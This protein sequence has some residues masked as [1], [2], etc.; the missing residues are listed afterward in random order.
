MGLE[1]ATYIDDLVITNP[2]GADDR[3]TADDHI[4]LVKAVLKTTFPTINGAVTASLAEINKLD[5]L[6]ASQTELNQLTSRTLASNDDV[7]DNF[8]AGILALFQQS[9]AP[10]GWT[11]QATHNNKALRVVSGTASSGGSVA[12]TTVFGRT[13]TDAYTLLEADVPAH[14]HGTTGDH[15]HASAGAHTHTVRTIGTLS[16]SSDGLHWEGSGDI[17][18]TAKAGYVNSNGSHTHANAGAHTHTSFG[19]GGSHTHGADMRV[20]YVDVIIASKD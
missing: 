6:T 17:L 16:G 8:E 12:F 14:D 7:I 18:D 15:G 2:A 20:T 11:K 13:A 1:S 10:T 3:S 5:G 4:R 19:G 9:A